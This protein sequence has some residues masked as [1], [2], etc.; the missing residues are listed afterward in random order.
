MS[1]RVPRG[2]KWYR[3][4]APELSRRRSTI[5]IVPS[6]AAWPHRR[7]AA[8]WCPQ[9]PSAAGLV[10]PS[11]AKYRRMNAGRCRRPHPLSVVLR[12]HCMQLFD[13]PSDPGMEVCCTRRKSVLCFVGLRLFDALADET[14]ILIFPPPAGAAW[15]RRHCS[16]SST[17]IWWRT[18]PTGDRAAFVPVARRAR[19][20]SRQRNYLP[21]PHTASE[22]DMTRFATGVWRRTRSGWPCFWALPICWSPARH[23]TA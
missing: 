11:P 17:C 4:S 8:V 6:F 9:P 12:V 21:R 7:H 19:E 13:N 20:V 22:S 2:E 16:K 5:P 15:S 10:L 3:D 14:T 23:A 18:S 1:V